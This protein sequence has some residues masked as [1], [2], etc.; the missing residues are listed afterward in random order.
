M[1]ACWLACVVGMAMTAPLA[2]AQ[3]GS[4]ATGGGV[5]S[6]GGV[7]H[8]LVAEPVTGEPYSAMQVHKTVR[9]LED[10]T[11]VSH[12]GHHFV[13]RDSTGRVRVEIRTDKGK[14]G[15]P[16]PATVF[17]SDPVAHT[18]T[19]WSTGQEAK[20]VATVVKLSGEQKTARRPVE[21]AKEDSSRPQPVVTKEK[22]GVQMLNGLAV[23][24]VKTTT[25]VPAGRSGNDAPI[26]KT[27]E[28]WTSDEMKLVMKEEW[29]D[30]RSGVRTLELSQFSRAEPD[31]ALF[32]APKGYEVKDM[33]QTLREVAQKLN[34]AANSE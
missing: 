21:T 2:Q 27:Q 32:H 25:V 7:I 4:V 10:G 15:Q 9:R 18:L 29:T 8:T 34:E 6:N 13:A 22:I 28:V 3:S 24:D 14:G 19:T 11:Q 17:V 23:T 31:A 1:R 16:D 20:H 5:L 12:Q 33:K 26:T 30:P